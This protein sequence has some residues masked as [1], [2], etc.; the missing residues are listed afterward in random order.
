[1]G[2]EVY[3]VMTRKGQITVPAAI[4]RALD[5]K[6]GDRIGLSLNKDGDLA[7]TLRRAPSITELTYGALRA[8]VKQSA[9]NVR[10]WRMQFVEQVIENASV[11]GHRR[12]DS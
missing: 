2:D 5:L 7:V 8:Y 3:T 12:D 1:M 9:N 6:K 4:R 11:E 10:E